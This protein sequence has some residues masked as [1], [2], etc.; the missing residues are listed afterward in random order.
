MAVTTGSLFDTHSERI[1]EVI[2]KSVDVMLPTMDPIW[3]GMITTSQGVGSVDAIGRDMEIIKVFQGGLTGVIESAA[4]RDNFPLFGD[5]GE[6]L[7]G[8]NR[9]HLQNPT[10]TFPD[11]RSGPNQ[12]PYRLKTPMRAIV[13]NIMFTMGEMN[14]EAL[15]AFIGQVIGP[16]LVGFG[17]NLSQYLCNYWYMSQNKHYALSDLGDA[18][19]WVTGTEG[20]G[21]THSPTV[22]T[23]T[24]KP[25]DETFDRYM[26]GMMVDIYNADGDVKRNY[27]DGTNDYKIYVLRVDELAGSVT[28][29]SETYDFSLDATGSTTE[30]S[31][32][33]TTAGNLDLETTDV[34]VFRNTRSSTSPYFTGIAGI[35]SWLKD[36]SDGTLRGTPSSGTGN[37]LYL[38]GAEADSTDRISVATYPEHKSMLYNMSGLP[39]TE[40]KLR[41]ILRRFHAAKR[42]YGQTIDCLIASDGVWLAYEATRMGREWVDRSSRIGGTTPQGMKSDQNFGGFSFTMDGRTYTGYTSTYVE[43][44]LV[45]GIKKGGNN[46]KRYVPPDFQG[47]SPFNKTKNGVPFRFVGK[48]LGSPTNKFPIYF[49]S[50]GDAGA[51]NLVSEAVQMPGWLR[52]QLIPDQPAGLKI[53]NC[54]TDRVFSAY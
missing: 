44:G 25:N 49:T 32:A 41:Q 53:I 38:L 15:P 20:A 11:P 16:K 43:K 33:P 42:R 45:Y 9:L 22:Y 48:A 12:T 40:H 46:W 7:L 54:G 6:T 14:A 51:M 47:L 34:V 29:V 35:N 23:F 50:S 30:S 27:N 28:L 39:L 10:N 2:N 26:P 18:S 8:T 36:G 5:D 1:E 4:P 3:S 21:T 31:G 24:F 37:D 52:M 19:D 17:Q 13:A